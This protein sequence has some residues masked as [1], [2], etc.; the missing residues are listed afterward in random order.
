MSDATELIR[1]IAAL[2]WPVAVVVIVLFFRSDI[3]GLMNDRLERVKAGPFVAEWN[4]Q[5]AEVQT[6]VEEAVEEAG[7]PVPHAPQV[8]PLTESFGELAML[9]PALAV[10]SAH[11]RIEDRLRELLKEAGA[12]G[13]VG[14]GGSASRLAEALRRRGVI[15]DEAARAVEGLNIM[16]SFVTH[17][18]T[19]EVTQEQA[20]DYLGLADAVLYALAHRPKAD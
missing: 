5:V 18:R 1:A 6:D 15:T 17:E 3:K 13:A 19:K 20:Q 12:P 2:A 14:K 8:G 11:A 16:R 9:N 7:G 4:R 10:V